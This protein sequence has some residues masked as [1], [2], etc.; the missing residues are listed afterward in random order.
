VIEWDSFQLL[1][2]EIDLGALLT[3]IA[4]GQVD[5]IEQD[6]GRIPDYLHGN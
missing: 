5:T 6:G 4:L 1:E 3:G 2:Q